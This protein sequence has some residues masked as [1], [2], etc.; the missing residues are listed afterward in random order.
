MLIKNFT[1]VLNHISD[2]LQIFLCV[3]IANYLISIK[4]SK[5][6]LWKYDN[7]QFIIVYVMIGLI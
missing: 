3:F 7:F 2:L 5:F 1:E 4:K 6:L